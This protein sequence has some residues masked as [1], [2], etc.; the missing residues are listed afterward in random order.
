MVLIAMFYLFYFF[1]ALTVFVLRFFSLQ[2]AEENI[3][4]GKRIFVRYLIV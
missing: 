4:A 3:E 2:Y 1:I